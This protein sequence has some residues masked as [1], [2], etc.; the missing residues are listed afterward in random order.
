MVFAR[1]LPPLCA[2]PSVTERGWWPSQEI[3]FTQE[4]T[5]WLLCGT[6]KVNCVSSFSST[7]MFYSGPSGSVVVWLAVCSNL[8]QVSKWFLLVFYLLSVPSLP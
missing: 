2:Q 4:K 7:V 1:A 3:G 5:P 8:V 6:Y